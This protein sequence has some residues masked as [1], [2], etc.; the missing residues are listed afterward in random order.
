M[1]ES[2]WSKEIKRIN[3]AFVRPAVIACFKKCN[4]LYG[5]DDVAE[6]ICEVNL[7]LAKCMDR[8]DESLS[9][10]AWFSR[11]AH[12]CAFDHVK[13]EREWCKMHCSME[14]VTSD[15]DLYELEFSDV[16][17][18]EDSR[19]DI[20]LIS[21]ERVATINKALLS[22]GE[23]DAILLGYKIDGYTDKEITARL[24]V[25]DGAC[26]TKI[27]RARARLRQNKEIRAL[28][29]EIFGDSYANVA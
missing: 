16:E 22:L 24:G 28:C 15:D 8:Y 29:S 4:Y 20:R 17:C 21:S 27:S 1:K 26:R 18:A 2:V 23:D 11:I 9:T 25:S 13:R 19:A 5:V 7:R 6:V 14:V 12:N 10:G 3:D